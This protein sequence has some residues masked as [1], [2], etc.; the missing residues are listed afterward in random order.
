MHI[1]S[2]N[3]LLCGNDHSYQEHVQPTI[4]YNVRY[5]VAKGL[6]VVYVGTGLSVVYL[7]TISA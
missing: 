1:R 2:S 7:G 5:G 4:Y 6:S 3:I